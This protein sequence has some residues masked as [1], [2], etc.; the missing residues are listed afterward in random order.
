MGFD[1]FLE[2]QL[3]AIY[4]YVII[5]G[6]KDSVCFGPTYPGAAPA[7]LDLQVQQDPD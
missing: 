5:V 7:A 6:V 2:L 1:M 4:T 3:A